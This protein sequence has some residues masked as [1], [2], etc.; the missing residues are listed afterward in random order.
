MHQVGQHP[1]V[2]QAAEAVLDEVPA[3]A[4]IAAAM[5]TMATKTSGR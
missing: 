3:P 2:G 1:G 4:A 5:T